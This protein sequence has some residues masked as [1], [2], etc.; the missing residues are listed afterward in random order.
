MSSSLCMTT[1]GY[2]GKFNLVLQPS[3]DNDGILIGSTNLLLGN[4]ETVKLSMDFLVLPNAEIQ[5]P[6]MFQASLEY[7]STSMYVK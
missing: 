1:L 5:E 3:Q 6:V 4:E 2:Y 7:A